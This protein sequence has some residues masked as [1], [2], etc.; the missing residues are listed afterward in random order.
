MKKPKRKYQTYSTVG[1]REYLDP[2][3]NSRVSTFLKY[4]GTHTFTQIAETIEEAYE[5]G[6]PMV[7]IL[8]HPNVRSLSLIKEKDYINVLEHSLSYFEHIENYKKCSEMK[9]IIE[10]VSKKKEVE[11]KDTDT[12]KEQ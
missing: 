5:Q 7:V 1:W 4:N 8:V 2:T 12:Y 11:I 9:N 6:L 10:K 3:Q